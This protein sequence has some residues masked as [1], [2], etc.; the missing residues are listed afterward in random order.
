[1]AAGDR[2][3]IGGRPN[4]AMQLTKRTEAGSAR[5]CA[6]S[7]ILRALRSRSPVFGGLDLREGKDGNTESLGCS[8]KSGG[9]GR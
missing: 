1:M 4:K 9:M 7:I 5:F 2:S 8:R 3:V 6:R